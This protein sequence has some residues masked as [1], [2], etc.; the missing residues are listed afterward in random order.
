MAIGARITSENLSGKTAT[1]TFTPYTGST[2]GT[3]QNLGTKVIP[4]NNITSHPYGIYNLYFAEYDYTYTLTVD[5]PVLSSQL[6]VHLNRMTTSDNFGVATLNFNDFTAEVIDF[7]INSDYWESKDIFPLTESGFGYYFRGRDNS[8]ERLI[9][10]TDASNTIVGQY[11]GTTEDYE[12]DTL[13]GKWIVFGDEDNGVL[14][15]F[16]GTEM[17]TYNWD[18]INYY[19]DIEWDSEAVMGDGSFILKKYARG[20]WTYNG[21]GSS[22]I[23]KPDG[24][25]IPFKTWTDVEYLDHMIVPT[26]DFI[27]VENRTQG[28][29]SIYTSLEIYNTDGEI[30]ET[31]SLTG[32]TYT[33]V[34]FDFLGT[35]RMCA[36]Y[37]NWDD[38][39]VDYKIIHYNGTTQT[40][41]ETSHVRG[42]NYPSTEMAGSYGFS[43]SDRVDGSVVI[44]FYNAVNYN[45]NIGPTCDYFD[46]VYMLNNQTEFTTYVVTN[47]ENRS[48]STSGT[49][50]NTYKV[51]SETT[52]NTIGLLTISTNGVSITDLNEPISGISNSDIYSIGDRAVAS[53]STNN[54]INYFFHLIGVDGSVLDSLTPTLTSNY[55]SNINTN[56]DVAYLRYT[57]VGDGEVQDG[58]YVYS[59]STGF[60]STGYYTNYDEPNDFIQPTFIEP[61]TMLL[62]NNDQLG[63]RIL[64][65]NG[66]TEELSFPE[67][68][69]ITVAV[70]K[71]KY[72]VVYQ[73]S[74]TGVVKINLHNFTGTLLNSRTT[75]YTTWDDIY[76]AKDR[77]VVVFLGEGTREYFLVSE[78]TITSVMMDD[79]DGETTIN[80]I[81]WWND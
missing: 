50:G 71:D 39:S 33:S 49:I 6:F 58:Y 16:N 74:E 25:V 36:V 35:D 51:W 2:S 12:F 7:G 80:D 18:P 68:N 40:L 15:Y 24:T 76:S 45:N 67:Y 61:S 19:I 11:S 29:S 78:E 3:T 31:V 17:F 9:I 70:G 56:G 73:E 62:W 10:F 72:M 34:N 63:Y 38:N 65:N 8:D 69:S 41:I 1:V 55:N 28:Q 77:F 32:A 47:D 57:R 75:N 59:G 20:Q 43:P 5:E 81:F 66:I 27:V 64:T 48:M 4:F 30:L 54:G 21:D 14:K 52:G 37:Y 22:Y 60:T 53:Y 42:I 23:M 79:F 13:N 26:I 46:F 44:S